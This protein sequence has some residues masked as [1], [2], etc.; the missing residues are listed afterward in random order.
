[1][2]AVIKHAED[3]MRPMTE[4]DLEQV[5]VIEETIYDFPWTR[6]IFRDCL[7]VGYSCWVL[8]LEG[9]VHAYGIVSMGAGE[10]HILTL[11]VKPASQGRGYGQLVLDYLLQI[12]R[13]HHIESVFLEVRPSNQA[14]IHLYKQSGFREVGLRPDYY[15]CPEGREDALVMA[16]ELGE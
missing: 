16:L 8:Q 1:M 15:P 6:G 11:C 7:Y 9:R 2:S 12:S 4:V 10:A 5:M 13:Q 3:G 14:A